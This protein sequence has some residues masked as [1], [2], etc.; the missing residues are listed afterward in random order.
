[1]RH[2][3]RLKSLMFSCDHNAFYFVHESLGRL[4]NKRF[5]K[6]FQDK[7]RCHIIGMDKVGI[8]KAVVSQYINDHFIGGKIVQLFVFVNE[9]MNSFDE[10]CLAPIIIYYPIPDMP[11]WADGKNYVKV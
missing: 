1:M 8:I 4:I 11:Y 5:S 7:L 9:M 3:L 6:F 2:C 10:S